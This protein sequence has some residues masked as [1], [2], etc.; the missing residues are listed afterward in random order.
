MQ[1]QQQQQNWQRHNARRLIWLD[2][3]LCKCGS[4]GNNCPVAVSV[5]SAVSGAIKPNMTYRTMVQ[6][7][8]VLA[9]HHKQWALGRHSL[10]CNLN[11]GEIAGEKVASARIKFAV[12]C[13]RAFCF[14]ARID[15]HTLSHTYLSRVL[16]RHY[17]HSLLYWCGSNWR[18]KRKFNIIES[19]IVRFSW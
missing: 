12:H 7:E 2:A 18:Q 5:I 16:H 8:R 6:R 13:V 4:H 3:T 17:N 9:Q 15:W 1:Q 10:C 19:A 14:S 11:H